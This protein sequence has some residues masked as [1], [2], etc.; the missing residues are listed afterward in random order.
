MNDTRKKT[1]CTRRGFLY[2]AG[3][4][5]SV[6]FSGG[7]ASASRIRAEV[8]QTRTITLQPRYY[9]GWSTLTRLRNG[10]LLV[11]YS[12][13]RQEH[14]CPFGRVELIVSKDEGKTWSWPRVILDSPVDDR[15][16][17]IVETAQGTIVVT[18]FTSLDYA[19]V[20]ER[21][22]EKQPGAPD[23]W[24]AGKLETWRAAHRRLDEESRR[25]EPGQWVIRSQD[26]GATWSARIRCPVNSPHGP[27]QLRDGP[28]LYAGKEIFTGDQQARVWASQDDGVSW[29]WLAD[30]PV[31]PGDDPGHY[32]ELHAVEAADGRLVAHIRNHNP[33][34]RGE[35]LQSESLD[36][37]KTWSIPR[38]I[39]VWGLP[40]FLLRLCNGDLLM[41]YGYRRPPFG[42]QARISRDNGQT[43]SEP[44]SISTDGYSWDLGYPSTAELE[45]G[46]LLT[47]WYELLQDSPL[48]VLRQAR[49]RIQKS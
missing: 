1:L 8:L 31:R 36:R 33:E 44:M 23:S 32:H 19:R 42:N 41:T 30:I 18:T 45:D 22:E 20:L 17:G 35:T 3:A 11:V 6:M 4:V 47:V 13:G 34:N 25:L 37:G 9:H 14:V 2:A 40:S 15:D 5:S 49:W 7:R 43:W 24:P 39:G 27:M 48:A 16:A 10:R 26:G 12:G 46:S 28:L 29:R 38:P 21:A